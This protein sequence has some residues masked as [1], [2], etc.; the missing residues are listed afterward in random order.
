M[1]KQK[2][3][4][5]VN[6]Y[7]G[8]RIHGMNFRSWYFANELVKK[9]H[10]PMI[11]T[12]SYSHLMHEPPQMSS[13]FKREFVEGVPYIWVK[14]KKYTG[15]KSFGRFLSMIDFMLKLFFLKKSTIDKPDVILVSSLSPFPIISAFFWSK[16]YKAKLLFEIRDLWPLSL[17]ELGGISRFHPLSLFFSFFERFGYKFSDKV[18]SLLPCAKDHMISKGMKPE[19][20]VYIPNG[21]NPDDSKV[22]KPLPSDYFE[23]VPKDKFIVGYTGSIGLANA[24]EYLVQAAKQME[25]DERVHFV[26][27]GKGQYKEKLQNIAGSNVTFLPIVDKA[28]VQN[29]LSKFNVCFIGLQHQNL[30]RFGISPNKMFEYMYAGKPIIQSIDAGNN[31]VEEAN[32]GFS[33]HPEDSNAIQKAIETAIEM[34]EKE[35][36]KLGS[37]GYEYGIKNHSFSSLTD[38]LVDLFA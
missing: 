6:Q 27:V 19:K 13:W 10:N 23:A 5:I 12:G 29:V 31:P 17:I 4:W 2:T 30:F 25:S 16:R 24:V 18:V 3:V 35:L 28:Q 21:F 36:E 11:I 34:P 9:G 32:A 38:R 22:A 15:S 33:V 8:S 26:I 1:E 37:N 14:V 20:F 7:C